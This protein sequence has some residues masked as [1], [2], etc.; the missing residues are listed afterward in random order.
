MSATAGAGGPA[1]TRAAGTGTTMPSPPAGGTMHGHR[2]PGTAVADEC[3]DPP[4]L[5]A[6]ERLP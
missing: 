5:P 2:S 1:V 4:P 3:P 6:Y